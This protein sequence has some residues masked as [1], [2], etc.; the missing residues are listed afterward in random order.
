MLI[1]AGQKLQYLRYADGFLVNI[2]SDFEG[3][4]LPTSGYLSLHTQ[5]PFTPLTEFS[6]KL[7]FDRD[8]NVDDS[9]IVVSHLGK[10]FFKYNGIIN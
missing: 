9:V 10:L 2:S 8:I 6:E 3:S 7:D 4:P 1:P 5:Q